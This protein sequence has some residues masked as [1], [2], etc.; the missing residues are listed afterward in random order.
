M[1]FVLAQS[2][3]DLLETFLCTEGRPLEVIRRSIVPK[4]SDGCHNLDRDTLEPNYGGVFIP[5]TP[6][7]P[8]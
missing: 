4:E 6:C 8:L 7:N 1:A 5:R 2:V 3:E